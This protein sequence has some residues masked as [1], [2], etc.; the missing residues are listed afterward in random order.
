MFWYMTQDCREFV[1]E[2]GDLERGFGIC[3]RD[4]GTDLSDWEG[5]KLPGCPNRKLASESFHS[6]KVVAWRNRRRDA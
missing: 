3:C 5:W 1:A 6:R 2:G 4:R